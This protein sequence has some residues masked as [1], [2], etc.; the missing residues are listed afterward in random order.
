MV[1]LLISCLGIIRWYKNQNRNNT[2]ILALTKWIH[3]RNQVLQ[4]A[5]SLNKNGTFVQFIAQGIYKLKLDPKKVVNVT[6]LLVH[7]IVIKS[8]VTVECSR[9]RFSK[10]ASSINKCSNSVYCKTLKTSSCAAPIFR[11]TSSN[12]ANFSCTRVRYSAETIH[13]EIKNK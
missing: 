13:Y 11:V 4:Y 12:S 7:K 9:I 8:S 3:A 6:T 2:F 5:F 10:M 1:N